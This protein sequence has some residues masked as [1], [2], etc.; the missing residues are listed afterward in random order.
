MAALF[1]ARLYS[2]SLILMV[3]LDETRLETA[4]KLD[5]HAN[6]N[7]SGP[8]TPQR[9]MDMTQGEEFDSVTEV[10]GIPAMFALCQQF[11]AVGGRLANVGVHGSCVDLHLKSL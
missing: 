9:L 8:D 5:A 4:R 1:T 10:V 6:V 2:P 3:Y 11:V 7:S